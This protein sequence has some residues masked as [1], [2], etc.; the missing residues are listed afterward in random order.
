VAED[1][2]SPFATLFARVRAGDQDAAARLVFEYESQIRR[3]IRIRMS[4]TLRRQLDS[5]DICQSVMGEF[6]VRSALGQFELQSPA[7]LAR[8]LATIA[9]NKLLN[10]VARQRT[11]KRSAH[12]EEVAAEQN[13]IDDA[14]P[15]RI[16]A[17]RDLLEA[18]RDRFSCEERQIA[19]RRVDGKSW[20]EIAAEFGESPDALRIRYSRAVQR[21]MKSLDIAQLSR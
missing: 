3:V 2:A 8:L 16:V 15:S 11:K 18:A 19:D 5:I 6:F 4:P 13:V 21:V 10:E 12:H 17:A 1:P 20:A 14:T 9:R 7:Q